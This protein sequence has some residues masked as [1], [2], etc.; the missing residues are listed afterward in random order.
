MEQSSLLSYQQA[1]EWELSKSEPPQ[2]AALSELVLSLHLYGWLSSA[3]GHSDWWIL[4][5]QLNLI[6]TYH[7]S[8]KTS[9]TLH[10]FV[11]CSSSVQLVHNI[12]HM[13][14]TWQ[15]CMK[16][17]QPTA[18]KNLKWTAKQCW[19]CYS[20][21]VFKISIQI[22]LE[23]R[24]KCLCMCRLSHILKLNENLNSG[25]KVGVTKG[26]RKT[27]TWRFWFS[28]QWRCWW[29]SSGLWPPMR[30]HGV[31]TQKMSINKH[32]LLSYEQRLQSFLSSS[33]LLYYL[34]NVSD[35][36]QLSHMH[37]SAATTK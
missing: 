1:A 2:Q 36:Y 19:F 3:E 5:S 23:G 8:H 13:G 12:L 35:I 25:S 31:T 18:E 17:L 14:H 26:R 37:R 6:T 10:Q 4:Q 27:K 29:W 15:S 34:P 16:L 22:L 30:Q 28:W 24:I 33:S 7:N 21:A 11:L 20:S 32:D 9:Y